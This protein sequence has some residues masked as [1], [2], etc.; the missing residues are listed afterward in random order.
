MIL[1]GLITLKEKFNEKALFPTLIPDAF[2]LIRD[3]TFAFCVA[4]CLDRGTKA[5][6]I[7]TIP[8]WIYE[9]V[10]HFNAQR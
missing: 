7:W 9:R 5:E 2:D 6:I 3:N 1:D 10:R 8:Y 4:T